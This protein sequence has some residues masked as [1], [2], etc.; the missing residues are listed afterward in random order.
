VVVEQGGK[1]LLR[2]VGSNDTGP[3]PQQKFWSLGDMRVNRD[4]TPIRY[5]SVIR[6]AVGQEVVT[7][8]SFRV[9]ERATRRPEERK[10]ELIEFNIVGFEF[11]SAE[12]R[13]QHFVQ[14][15]EVAKVL[16]SGADVSITGF[17]DR[18]GDP[19]GNVQLSQ[20]RA[21]AVLGALRTM[22]ERAG[23]SMPTKLSVVGLGSDQQAYDNDLP[24]GRLL[25]R[26]VRV[27]VARQSR[28]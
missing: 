3:K 20:A 23:E 14:L 4:L 10:A 2:F 16:T 21:R 27:T 22:R 26:M 17:T 6:D 7:E 24:E 28:R 1:E 8:G 18:T 25:S 15:E 19:G 11:N 9:L 5:R 13:P 12:L